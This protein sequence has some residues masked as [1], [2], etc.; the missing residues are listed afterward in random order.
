MDIHKLITE[1]KLHL[2]HLEDLVKSSVE[3]EQLLTSRVMALEDDHDLTWGQKLADRV[4]DFGGSWLFI[5]SFFGIIFVWISINAFSLIRSPWD[6]YPF[7]LLNLVLSC[8]AALQAPV[9]MMSQNRQ[10]EKDRRRARGDFLVNMKAEMEIRGLSGKVDV[11]L[12]EQ[13]SSLFKVQE[14]Q[15]EILMRIDRHTSKL[16]AS[17]NQE[18]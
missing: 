4:A 3:E 12:T 10:E 14:A 11:L 15:L 13:M 1:E 6:P 16:L 8:L 9:I 2:K 17:K 18:L 7:I 5:L